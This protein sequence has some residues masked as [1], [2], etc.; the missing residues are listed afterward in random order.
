MLSSFPTFA[1][2]RASAEGM[3]PAH[4]EISL[5]LGY[6]LCRLETKCFS[7]KGFAN[8]DPAEPKVSW[9][10]KSKESVLITPAMDLMK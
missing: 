9:G 8:E 6:T 4:S 10:R 1:I 2:I 3:P 5:F 7:L